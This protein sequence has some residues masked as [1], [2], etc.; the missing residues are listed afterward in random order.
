MTVHLSEQTRRYI[1]KRIAAGV[2]AAQIQAE[3]E[4]KKVRVPFSQLLDFD[5][6]RKGASELARRTREEMAQMMHRARSVST[7]PN[8]SAA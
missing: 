5:P 8:S 1:A 4:T 3:L 2:T 6:E 7:P